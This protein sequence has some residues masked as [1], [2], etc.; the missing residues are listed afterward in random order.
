MIRLQSGQ[1]GGNPYHGAA[2]AYTNYDKDSITTLNN[3]LANLTHASNSNTTELNKKKSSMASEMTA[4]RTT[5]GQQAQQ[6]ANI[7]TTPTVATPAWGSPPAWAAPPTVPTNIYLNPANGAT[8]PYAPPPAA[9]FAPT[10]P[11]LATAG[12]SPPT[13]ASG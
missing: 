9:N 6:L 8:N 4:L 7:A 2:N 5:V 10:I 11:P 13:N 12:I 3:T 1:S